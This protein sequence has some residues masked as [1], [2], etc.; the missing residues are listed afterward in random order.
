MELY[1]FL[2]TSLGVSGSSLGNGLLLD[3]EVELYVVSFTTSNS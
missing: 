3:R 2:D 1:M